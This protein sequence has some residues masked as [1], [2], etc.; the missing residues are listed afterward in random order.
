MSDSLKGKIYVIIS[1]IIF[2]TVGIFSKHVPLPSGAV[3]LARSVI[4]LLFL[5][6]LMP[7]MKKRPSFF[8]IRK[9]LALL[10]ASGVCLGLNW[11]L[12]FAACRETTVPTATL[13]YYLAP[14]FMVLGS[15]VFYK[16]RIS[17][18]RLGAVALAL[19]GMLFA[20]G[21]VE[22][23]AEGVTPLGILFGCI[24]AVIYAAIV[25]MNKRMKDIDSFDKTAVQFAVASLV[26]APYTAIVEKPSVL[27]VDLK[28]LL[29]LLIIGILHTGVAY[30]LYFGSIGKLS[31]ASVGMLGYIDPVV[32]IAVSVVLFSEPITPLALFGAVLIIGASLISELYGERVKKK[33]IKNN[34]N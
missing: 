28:C 30:A 25:L 4:G 23:G 11:L 19:V 17:L 8:A 1:M 21:V 6:V 33:G 22:G 12:F 24:A 5:S 31:A 14:A 9:N 18:F 16:E 32:S 7:V 13:A 10:I 26:L 15:F 34:E 3:A 29:L 27:S 20:S 2:G